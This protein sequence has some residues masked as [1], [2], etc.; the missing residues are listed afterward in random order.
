MG[1]AWHGLELSSSGKIAEPVPGTAII[2]I[3]FVEHLCYN[4]LLVENKNRTAKLFHLWQKR[5]T[6]GAMFQVKVPTIVLPCL[7]KK[8]EGE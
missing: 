8:V 1:S 6:I 5:D 7:K 3:V 4:F 2:L